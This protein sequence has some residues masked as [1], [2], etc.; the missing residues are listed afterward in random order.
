MAAGDERIDDSDI[1]RVLAA[2]YA[3]GRH[4]GG[5]SV[6]AR[7]EEIAQQAELDGDPED[8]WWTRQLAMNHDSIV[9]SYEGRGRS[10]EVSRRFVDPI[11]ASTLV[12]GLPELPLQ[13]AAENCR[14]SL[15]VVGDEAWQAYAAEV[16]GV[17]ESVDDSP[18]EARRM[19]AIGDANWRSRDADRPDFVAAL[20]EAGASQQEAEWLLAAAASRRQGWDSVGLYAQAR[21]QRA[22][23]AGVVP[24]RVSASPTRAEPQATAVQQRPD[25]GQAR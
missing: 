22:A 8:R 10:E 19:V 21:A 16:Q 23:T 13:T 14:A 3:V 5:F 17:V 1:A 9:A 2:D 6:P 11:I 15:T 4:F 25:R 18:D 7:W 20:S 24:P 12:R